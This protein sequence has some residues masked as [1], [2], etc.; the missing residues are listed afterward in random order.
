MLPEGK[1]P[2]EL[3]KEKGNSAFDKVIQ[4]ALP[5]IEYKLVTL[6]RKFNLNEFDGKAKYVDEAI[7]V[8]TDISEVEAEV[9]ID[10]I[11][12][13]S[14]VYKDFLRK[15]LKDKTL[16]LSTSHMVVAKIPQR[17]IVVDD[18]QIKA[19]ICLL[20]NIVNN[21]EYVKDVQKVVKLLEERYSVVTTLIENNC[22]KSEI[23]EKL[24]EGNEELLGS[25]INYNFFIFQI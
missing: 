17:D 16:E 18:N 21:K 15:K 8:L 5:L 1:D 14:G 4:T 7:D 20:A 6:K 12:D 25:I 24:N 3:I 9:Y 2:D 10:L 23:I 22:T 19:E 11:S 13:I